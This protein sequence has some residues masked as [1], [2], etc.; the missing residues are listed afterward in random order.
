V[1]QPYEEGKVEIVL[2]TRRFRGTKT[3]AL[4]LEMENGQT[5]ET[6]FTVT[7]D[8]QDE[9]MLSI[10]AFLPFLRLQF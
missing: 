4:Y 8:S 1:L 6:K 9:P 2:D 3:S 5:I 7:A 10:P